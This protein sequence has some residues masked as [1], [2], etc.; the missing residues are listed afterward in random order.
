MF[1][2]RF[3]RRIARTLVVL[4]GVGFIQTGIS[5][6]AAQAAAP[7]KPTIS[8]VTSGATSLTVNMVT[9]GIDA[10]QWRW[11][12]TIKTGV[13]CA[14]TYGDGVV[15]S[16]G[17]LSSTIS[18]TGLTS[19]C[20]Y[21]V[22]V[23]GFNGSI[24]EYA[25]AEKLVG[26]FTNGLL[27]YHKN[28]SGSSTAMTRVPFTTGTCGTEVFANINKNWAAAG[29]TGCNSDGFTTYYLGYIK[30]PVTGSVTFKNRSDD[31]FV[32][33]I[34]GQ[35]IITDMAD[36]A[37]A[38]N[39][40]YNGT[41]SINM[42]ANEIY[43]IEA[44][45]HENSSGAD[46][47]LEWEYSGQAQTVVPSSFLATDPTVFF[48]YCPLGLVARCAAGSA[49]EIKQS[50]GTNMDGNY[51]IM[52]NGTPT[53]TYCIMN[54]AMSGGG[55]MLAMKGKK[56]SSTFSYAS[57]YWTNTTQ[58]N[59]AYPE[60]WKTGDTQ[61]DID[62]KYGVFSY[63]KGNQIMALFPEQSGY[64]GGAIAAGTTGNTTTP[65]GFSWIETT[66][67]GRTWTSSDGN[68]WNVNLSAYGGPNGSSC[69]T[70][71]TTLTNLFTNSNRCL[72][73][74]V[75]SS[76]SAAE[77]PYSA[78]GNGL[79][80]T[81]TQI[82]FFG[83]N[84]GS[85][86]SGNMALARWGFG[87]N[88][89][90]AGDESSNDGSAGIGI[91]YSSYAVTAGSVNGCC[92][93]Q[94]G[95][96]GGSSTGTNIPFE[97]YV[98]NSVSATVSGS[99]IRVTSKRSSSANYEAGYTASGT[100]GSNT[101]RLSPLYEGLSI[102][103]S[104]GI[105]TVS[106]AMPVG[107]YSTS[108]TVTDTNG[109]SGSKSVTV[110]VLA[111]SQETDTA[112]NFTG[113]AT[114]VT[115][116]TM[117]LT[118]NQTW[119][120]WV[121]PTS[122][123]N[124]VQK[125]I[126]GSANFVVMC[127]SGYWNAGFRETSSWTTVQTSQ[128]IVY[129]AWTHI[130]VVRSGTTVSVYVNNARTRVNTG[131]AWADTFNVANPYGTA[132]A[133]Y[134]GGYDAGQYFTGV[135]D[136]FKVW[137][138]ARTLSQ[139]TAGMYAAPNIGSANLVAYWD[140]NDGAGNPAVSR[141]L[142][143]TS[144]FNFSPL[145]AQVVP[146][147]TTSTSGP[148]TVITFPR[149]LI[150]VRS[151]WRVPDSVTAASVLLVGGGGGGAGS[152]TPRTMDPAGAGGAGGVYFAPAVPLIPGSIMPVTVGAGGAAGIPTDTR[153]DA[154]GYSGATTSFDALSAG[155]GGAGGYV[156]AAN[157]DGLPGTAGGAGGGAS[158][159]WEALQ[160]GDAGASSS[161][162][163]NGKTF[164]ATTTAGAGSI[165]NSTYGY[166]YNGGGA[167]GSATYD[168]RGIGVQSSITG[169]T[170]TYGIGGGGY[171][172]AG[173]S[174]SAQ[175]G[176]GNGGDGNYNESTG[177]AQGGSG[178][179]VIRYITA[180]KP[181]FT[182]PANTTINLGMVESFTTNAMSDSATAGLTRTFRW[183]STTTGSTG[184]YSSIKSGTGIANATFNWTPPDTSTSGSNYLYRVV[185]T[186]SDS[187]GLFIVDTS[188]A[189]Y[190]V[191]NGTLSLISK[192]TITKTVNISKSETF[193]VLNGTPTY[194]Y[195]LT[196]D[197]PN[198][199]LDTSVVGSPKIR[200]A[201]TATVGTYYETFTVIDSI[202]A[203]ITVPLT[204]VISPPPSFSANAP[205]VDSGTVLYLDAGNTSSYSGTGTTWNDLSG[206]GLT[207]TLP[208]SSMPSQKDGTGLTCYTP[209]FSTSGTPNLVFNGSSTCGYV[210]NVGLLQ[211]YTYEVW[212]MRTGADNAMSDY[213]SIIASPFS[214]TGKQIN[215]TL[216]WRTNGNLVA[217][218][219]DGSA[220]IE[221]TQVY[222]ASNIWNYVAVTYDGT[223]LRL[224]LNG[225][226][227]TKYSVTGAV[228]FADNLNDKGLLIG[229]RFDQNGYFFSG[230]VASIRLYNRVLSDSEIQQNYNATKG[231]FATTQNKNGVK[232][233]YGSRTSET[234]TVTAGSESI[235]ATFTA[236]AISRIVWDTST[237]RSIKLQVQESLTVGV[238]TDTITVT[239][240]YGSSTSLPIRIE[241]GKAA[242]I[243]ISMDTGTVTTYNG[244]PLSTYPR[245]VIKGLKNSDTGTVTTKFSSTLYS[246]SS[247]PPTNADTY[248]VTAADF[249]FYVGDIS[250]YISVIYETS[251]AV[252][253][254]ARQTPLNVS[255]YGALVGSPFTITLLGGSGDGAVVETLTGTS[256]A[257]NCAISNHVLSSG[258]TSISYCQILVTKAQSQN[259]LSESSTVQVYFMVLA[260]NQPTAAVGS[261]SGIG[262]S[263]ATAIERDANA[264]PIISSLSVTSGAVGSS[265]IITGSG[266]YFADPSKLSIKFWRNVS[267]T[268]YTITNDSSVTVTVPVG[269]T[270]GR[271]V[272]TNPYGLAASSTFT[273]TP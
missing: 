132:G 38:A 194:R 179:I 268:I 136:E 76:Y 82:R 197:G 263:G 59:D 218:I 266:F 157:Q 224:S 137:S 205:Q 184:T 246:L 39:G 49:L 88:E 158:N 92:A 251:T 186:D 243:T 155:G 221:T 13:S 7:I 25:E 176:T 141:A 147:A 162:S 214:G 208:P 99:N 9:T 217:G 33:N 226:T 89:N 183:E 107:T 207:A 42:V 133:F 143:S 142:T 220:W 106:E 45:Y 26:G 19:G 91:T 206:R 140:F 167:G 63:N 1:L 90:N 84:Y 55:W 125:S 233:V 73:R 71:A 168:A 72:F 114:L 110:E 18:I 195:T 118:G 60:R 230:A 145:S 58:L 248:T 138:E 151:G 56:S 67:A 14:N 262:I 203:S 100:N 237:A 188:T 180:L 154:R 204:I 265:V 235:T 78:I 227:A 252:I 229:K 169:I 257:P 29:P 171:G 234:Y 259:Y 260:I 174:F 4:L 74:Q 273:V 241:V 69:V 222:V 211:T 270:S 31:G 173:W 160:K 247:T 10:T 68:S 50:T 23:A 85:N 75:S 190:A 11:H 228:T 256:T 210:P 97:M 201:D 146:V 102:N 109:V 219:W 83:I 267:A 12:V 34:Q 54:S 130:A 255:M 43:R 122:A 44:W 53:L 152:Y 116:A 199:S 191:I 139:I 209:T 101:F 144:S 16:T 181:S 98:R 93:T 123:C 271:I 129:D 70:T 94:N 41:G 232:A 212:F 187:D 21:S 150:S 95:I 245:P 48:G 185:V 65:Y 24:G 159:Y 177:G 66:T 103:S 215:I 253:N 254:R 264:A 111:D 96:S 32:L 172:I 258:A 77:S 2:S 40:S 61:R 30:A 196:P 115:S 128:R 223:N 149:T 120:A 238:Y 272:L 213:S 8:S 105:L 170:V 52:V 119:E 202:S 164:A 121:K 79:F 165:Y 161:A 126:F 231:R 112:I 62:A 20:S 22:K 15:Q 244:A 193:T 37:S 189:V 127:I 51:W 216:H 27:A 17:S 192:L 86:T 35:N 80:F 124:G 104:T 175:T 269:A 57:T 163:V 153:V 3:Q 261:G 113:A 28:E 135:V 47:N 46:V 198:F 242:S 64:A 6:T 36:H 182:K 225:V 117:L 200:I 236:N 240:I 249:A 108:V 5:L 250:N 131:G 148:Y 156:D 166:G 87:W 239:D 134:V 178:L 81:Q